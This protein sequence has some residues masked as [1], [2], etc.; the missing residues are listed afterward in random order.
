MG[1]LLVAHGGSTYSDFLKQKQKCY[2][3]KG[4]VDVKH[5]A[6]YQ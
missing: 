4:T 6:L 5:R 2:E 3:C 1:L